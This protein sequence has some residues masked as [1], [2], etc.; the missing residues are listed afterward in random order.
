MKSRPLRQNINSKVDNN[1]NNNNNNN[2]H[3]TRVVRRDISLFNEIIDGVPIDMFTSGLRR[4][5]SN[6]YLSPM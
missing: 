5:N 2:T 3:C 1:N 4:R 6:L